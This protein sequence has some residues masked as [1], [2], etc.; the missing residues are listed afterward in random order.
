MTKGQDVICNLLPTFNPLTVLACLEEL[1]F[2]PF[3]PAASRAIDLLVL[4]R[5]EGTP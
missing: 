5:E 4:A 2:G 1:T 3:I